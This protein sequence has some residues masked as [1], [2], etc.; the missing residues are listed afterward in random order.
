MARNPRWRMN[1]SK[2]GF[3]IAT[4]SSWKYFSDYVK[5]ILLTHNQFI[6]RGQLADNWKLESTLDRALRGTIIR[7]RDNKRKQ[8]L[9]NIR[10]AARGRRG[11]NP[12]EIKQENE[13]WAIGQ[14]NGLDT[15]L[16]DWTESP[17][18]ALFFA[19]SEANISESDYRV[20]WCLYPEGVENKSAEI[21]KRIG[22][23]SRGHAPIIE[24]VRPLS[25]ENVRLVSQRGLFVRGPDGQ[26]IEQWIQKHFKGDDEY[27]HLLKVRIP[28]AGRL[29]CLRF[30]NRMNIN[31]L[32]L[33]PDLFGA[34]QHCN[35][36]LQIKNY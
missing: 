19:F 17:F 27:T 4:L 20:V 15:P 36:D 10:Y 32:S 11:P 14:H 23:A 21:K 6:Y 35:M 7:E 12:R 31:Y 22:I 1:E 24:F 3:T 30:L 29:D 5:Q 18:V 2:A 9:N 28:N 26:P 33:F 34:S 16:L 13:W 25:D 8:H